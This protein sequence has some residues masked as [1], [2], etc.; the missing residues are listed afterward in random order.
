MK[1]I[2]TAAIA[3]AQSGFVVCEL[4]VLTLTV[5]AVAG[6]DASRDYNKDNA[7]A[8]NRQKARD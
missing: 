2:V 7:A 5:P 4:A 3:S 6:A 8:K 1:G